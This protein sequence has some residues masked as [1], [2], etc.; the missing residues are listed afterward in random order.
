MS[1]SAFAACLLALS[2]LIS[3]APSIPSS[4][5]TNLAALTTSTKSL[6]VSLK[7]FN[8]IRYYEQFAAASYCGSNIFGK[9]G[10]LT[11][12]GAGNRNAN[13]CPEV[14]ANGVETTVKF[15]R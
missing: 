9:N 14:Q 15:A 1:L 12:T 2:S 5:P 8:Y 6:A 4:N 11:C 7:D 13:N 3:A 10:P